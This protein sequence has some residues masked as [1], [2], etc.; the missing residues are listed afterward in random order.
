MPPDD[1]DGLGDDLPGLHDDQWD[2]ADLPGLDDDSPEPQT[3][4][5]PEGDP[6]DR[7]DEAVSEWESDLD[8]KAEAR[9]KAHSELD[10]WREG[11]GRRVPTHGEPWDRLSIGR[12]AEIRQDWEESA[13]H[14]LRTY[15]RWVFVGGGFG[16]L[17]LVLMVGF[18]LSS[19]DADDPAVAVSSEA[20]VVEAAPPS[21]EATVIDTAVAVG[22]PDVSAVP[23]PTSWTYTATKTASIVP[24]P[25]FMTLTPVG[26]VL[27][28]AFNV[29]ETCQQEVCTYVTVIDLLMP[30]PLFPAIPETTWVVID[31]GWSLDVT[32]LSAQSSYGDGTICAIRNHDTFELTVT[33]EVIDGRSIPTAF[34]GTWIQ[35]SSLDLGASS[36]NIDLYCGEPWEVVDEWSLV[37]V[38]G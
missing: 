3:P 4:E 33:N 27:S 16:I 32:H 15:P 11:A 9:E 14:Q 5:Q 19:G 12:K 8:A 24:A 28:W 20:P 21:T 31:T 29:T 2:D 17:G 23:F 6:F 25:D 22:V 26:A 35:A 1:T 36:G 10:A 37:G 18:F 13:R 7:L 30:D 34:T 38:T